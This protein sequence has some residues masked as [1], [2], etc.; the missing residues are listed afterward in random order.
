MTPTRSGRTAAGQGQPQPVRPDG[1]PRGPAHAGRAGHPARR[2]AP[3]DPEQAGADHRAAAPARRGRRRRVRQDP[4]DGP[5]GRLAGRQRAGRAA[6]RARPHLHPQGRGRARRAGPPDAAA[7]CAHAHEHVAVPRRRRRGGAAHRRAD[8]HDLPLL[9][10]GPGRRARAA[11][12]PRAE[13]PAGRR[14]GQLAVRR[15]GR[16]V[17]TTAPMDAVDRAVTTV[18]GDVLALAGELAEHLRDADDVR[19]ADRAGARAPRVAAA[20]AGPAHGGP[21]QGRRASCSTCSR[22]GS[23]C[24]R[25]SSATP[26]SSATAASMD[27]GDQVAVAARIARDAPGGRRDRA[28]PVRRGAARRV[29]GH[30]R[31]AAGAAHVAVRAGTRSPRSATRA[32]PST[33]GAARAPATSSGSAPTS[34]APSRPG[35][36]GLTGELPQRRGASWPSPT[37]SPTASRCAGLDDGDRTCARPRPRGRRARSWSRCT[38][39][40]STRPTWVADQVAGAGA[41]DA[42][43]R[44]PG[45]RSRCWRASGRTSP[46]SRRRCAT[47]AS[48]ARSSASAACCS[49]PRSSTSSAPCGCWPTRR[50][51]RALV[52]LLAGPRW[53]LGPR[54]LDALGRRARG[55]PSAGSCRRRPATA[56]GRRGS[57]GRRPR[58]DRRARVRR[59][60]RAQPG[61]RPRRPGP[62]RALL[63]PTG[64]A[65]LLPAARRA[66]PAA[67][68][69]PRQLAA[70]PGDGRRPLRSAWTSSSRPARAC[71]AVDALL[72][73]DRLVE[74][75]EEFV[76]S[77]EDP[78]LLAFLAYLD[79]AEERER[80]LEV[81]RGRARRR[82]GAAD[83]RARGQGPG[84]GRRRRRRADARRCSRSRASRSP[85]GPSSSRRCRSRCA[86]T[87]P[88][89]PSCAGRTPT[90]QV[91]AR[92]SCSTAFRA[93]LPGARRARGAPARLRRGHPGPR[94]CWSARATGGTRRKK[95]R[96][97]SRCSTEIARAVPG[98]RR[99]SRR[100]GR[101]AGPTTTPTRWPPTRRRRSG[102]TT[103]S[104]QRRPAVEAGCRRW[105]ARQLDRPCAGRRRRATATGSRP[106]TRSSSCCSPSSPASAAADGSGAVELPATLSVSQLVELRRDPAELARSLRRPLPR[107]PAPQARRGTRF[108]LWLEQRWGQQRLLDVDELPGAADDTAEPTTTWLALQEAFRRQR[109]VVAGAG[110]GRVPLRPGRRRA[111][112]ARPLRR[113]LHR[114]TRR[115]RRR[116]R[117]EDRAAQDRRRGRRRGG[118]ARGLPAGL[119]PP[120]RRR[121]WTASAPRSTTSAANAPCGPPTCSTTRELIE[122]IRSVPAA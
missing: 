35:R 96:G 9:R 41:A 95:Q 80:G 8:R 6:P 55:W 61:R 120:H 24:C 36:S 113:R 40:S 75:A 47:G 103:R 52:R 92:T 71:D 106:G 76:A 59:R 109:V 4:D 119:A 14:G 94:R 78:G 110:R 13:H 32:S 12:R 42:R 57:D 64:Y 60:R 65:R 38:R 116:R 73:V 100:L 26:R 5:A 121:R 37:W 101:G 81:E 72:D 107:Q 66:A 15:A 108:H 23:P 115:H 33:A 3:A 79:T 93:G 2:V 29:P 45:A 82:A 63:A 16:R 114:R 43:R 25:W 77:G 54:D 56:A 90:D 70:R 85:T 86:A 22:R 39:P 111:A 105:S 117:L 11:D 58:R 62:R 21:L 50:P 31:G 91:D 122:L 51:A 27:Y 84:V 97:P 87:A 20:G 68:A 112:A 88:S 49:S 102:P 69:G 89:C 7:G 53:R 17:A 98:R 46:G 30:R 44:S 67:A 48:R 118:P 1:R 104:G 28:R 99:A 18:I 19:G 74:V 34:P 10:R 83:D